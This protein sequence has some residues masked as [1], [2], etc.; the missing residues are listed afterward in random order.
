M[1]FKKNNATLS[2][3]NFVNEDGDTIEAVNHDEDDDNEEENKNPIE[4][5]QNTQISTEGLVPSLA[6]EFKE[7][8]AKI[9]KLVQMFHRSPVRNDDD[10]QPNIVKTF[11]KE[12]V[13]ICDLRTRW[14]STIAMLDEANTPISQLVKQQFEK[15]IFERRNINLIH[16]MKYLLNPDVLNQDDQFGNKIK[17]NITANFATNIIQRLFQPIEEDSDVDKEVNNG[18]M[19]D[20]I[21]NNNN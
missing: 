12:K 9:R 14:S 10:L 3:N 21:R 6:T 13:L 7:P 4:Y 8:V 2:N 5:V 18:D 1:L 15:T 11:G 19:S 20:D 17:R 16:L